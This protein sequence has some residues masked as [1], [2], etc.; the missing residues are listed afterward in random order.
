MTAIQERRRLFPSRQHSTGGRSHSERGLALAFLIGL[1]ALAHAG[2]APVVTQQPASIMLPIAG[3]LRLSCVVTGT[4]PISVV[5]QKDGVFVGAQ[6]SM[7]LVLSNAQ[8]SDSGHYRLVASNDDGLARS[9]AAQVIVYTNQ[10]CNFPWV[11][12]YEHP[13]TNSEGIS[14][15]GF[16]YDVAFDT[17]GNVFVTGEDDRD[18]LTLKFDS[19]GRVLWSAR[20]RGP[21]PGSSS[22]RAFALALD[23]AGNCFVAG[24]SQQSNAIPEFIGTCDYLANS[25][26]P[27]TAGPT[28]AAQEHRRHP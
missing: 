21:I 9:D 1:T 11:W 22:D 28:E 25:T 24:V 3:T 18:Y 4:E 19:A 15:G 20:Y 27:S 23:S 26:Q 12:A 13:I 6:T 7:T 14:G 8:P 5:W 2:T 16:A 17:N 10:P